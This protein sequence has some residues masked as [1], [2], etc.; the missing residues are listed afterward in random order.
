MDSTDLWNL[1]HIEL[2]IFSVDN[3]QKHLKIEIEILSR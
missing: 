1:F 3:G 2:I